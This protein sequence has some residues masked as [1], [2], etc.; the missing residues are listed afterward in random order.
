[1]QES[2]DNLSEFTNK[3]MA[4][5]GRIP[6]SHIYAKLGINE[7]TSTMV[8]ATNSQKIYSKGFNLNLAH[9]ELKNHRHSQMLIQ[10]IRQIYN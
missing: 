10:P 1:M 7:K 9:W 8:N 5:V 4:K 6:K 3:S 2:I